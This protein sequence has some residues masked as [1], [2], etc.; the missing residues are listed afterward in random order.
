MR[1][2]LRESLGHL[3]SSCSCICGQWKVPSFVNSVKFPGYYRQEMREN[4]CLQI[5]SVTK[6]TYFKKKV[7]LIFDYIN[8]IHLLFKKIRAYKRNFF[9]KDH[10]DYP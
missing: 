3:G 8:I 2:R 4:L 6:N 5:S 10:L 7:L 1:E 9:K